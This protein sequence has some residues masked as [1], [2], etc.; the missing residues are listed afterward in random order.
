MEKS[1]TETEMIDKGFQK[2]IVIYSEQE[3]DCPY[4]LSVDGVDYLLDPVNLENA[5]KVNQEKIWVT[6]RSLRMAN[7]CEKATPIEIIEIE[8]RQ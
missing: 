5:F 3:R 4:T 6:Y 8:K 7:R 2:A 1:K